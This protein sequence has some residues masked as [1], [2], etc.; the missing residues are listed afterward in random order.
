VCKD[1]SSAIRDVQ[2]GEVLLL[3]YVAY[4]LSEDDWRYLS[5]AKFSIV[6]LDVHY[7]AQTW[8]NQGPP[9]VSY[10]RI[11]GDDVWEIEK[12]KHG[13][14]IKEPLFTEELLK[15]PMPYNLERIDW[16][17]YYL[18][19]MNPSLRFTSKW[20]NVRLLLRKKKAIVVDPTDSPPILDS[21]DDLIKRRRGYF[22]PFGRECNLD[23]AIVLTHLPLWFVSRTL[24]CIPTSN[25]SACAFLCRNSMSRA[26]GDLLWFGFSYTSDLETVDPYTR[27]Q[28]VCKVWGY[29]LRAPTANTDVIEVDHDKRNRVVTLRGMYSLSFSYPKW[30]LKQTLN[31]I[32]T[33]NIPDKFQ[34]YVRESVYKALGIT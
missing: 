1:I 3:S 34:A 31:V 17:F 21:M 7:V 22:V 23:E 2:D 33:L 14:K 30:K 18:F 29:K 9:F 15:Q 10:A 13:G 26:D 20:E 12:G 27:R 32:I 28:G 4:V 25:V 5:K 24:Y 6:A 8:M 16:S 19:R 11:G